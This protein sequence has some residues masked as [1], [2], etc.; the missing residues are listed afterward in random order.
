M[1]AENSG[2]GTAGARAELFVLSGPDVGRSFDIGHGA[3]VGRAPDRAVILRDKSISR[4]HAHFECE[5]G[6]WSIVDDGSTNG[7]VVDGVRRERAELTDLRE[8]LIGEVLVRL[9][10]GASSDGPAVSPAPVRVPSR[11]PEPQREIRPEPRGEFEIED[12][13]LLDSAPE[14]L[15]PTVVR[16]A[17]R[18]TP[19]ITVSTPSPAATSADPGFEARGRKVLQFHK[20]EARSGVLVTDL[21]QRPLWVRGLLFLVVGAGAALL[22][23]AVYQAVLSMRTE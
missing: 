22:A 9:R 21:S 14:P 8:F 17:P 6:R 2:A 19:S 5:G 7:F 13:I 10:I 20:V 18:S 11:T 3:S 23:W 16:S 15:L 1:A 12:E 4:H